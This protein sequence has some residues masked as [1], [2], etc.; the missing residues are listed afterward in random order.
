MLVEGGAEV[1]GFP[2]FTA[3]IW[4]LTFVSSLVLDQW[5]NLV[6][7]PSTLR[8]FVQFLTGVDCLWCLVSA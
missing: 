7:G 2:T 6:A 5:G 3:L 1:E 8:T 4:L